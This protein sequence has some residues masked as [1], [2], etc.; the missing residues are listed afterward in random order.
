MRVLFSSI[1][2]TGGNTDYDSEMLKHPRILAG[3]SDG[4][5]DP[6][7]SSAA[8]QN[9]LILGPQYR[10]SFV[11]PRM[12]FG[13]LIPQRPARDLHRRRAADT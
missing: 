4:G 7:N 3:T 2:N 6:S 9:R 8:G 5:A 1:E 12:G 10:R 13:T 11:V